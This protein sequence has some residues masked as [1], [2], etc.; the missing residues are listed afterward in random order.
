[1]NRWPSGWIPAL[2]DHVNIPITPFT[3]NGISL[4]HRSTPTAPWTNN[5]LGAP[6]AHAQQPRALDTLYAVFPTTHAFREYMDRIIGPNG[7]QNVREALTMGDSHASLWRAVSSLKW[8]ASQT[9]TDWPSGI[10]DAIE[11]AYKETLTYVQ[12]EQR[13]TGGQMMQTHD[14]HMPTGQK[15]ASIN[16]ATSSIRN[17][18]KALGKFNKG[19]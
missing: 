17:A 12:P 7:I 16:Q 11:S 2:L 13:K 1:M 18:R 8:P 5:P 19:M 14:A 10:L 15:G 9:E 4:W 3:V 6:A